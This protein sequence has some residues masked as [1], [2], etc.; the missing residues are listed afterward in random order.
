MTNLPRGM[1]GGPIRDREWSVP[2][3]LG[4]LL[5]L[6]Y[7]RELL[8]L[9]ILVNDCSDGTRSACQW[10]VDRARDEG[11]YRAELHEL[12]LGTTVDNNA[13]QVRD[14]R[15]YAVLRSKWACLCDTERW[16]FSVDSDVQVPHWTLQ[17]LVGLAQRDDYDLLAAVIDN[18]WAPAPEHG[19]NVLV[20]DQDGQAAHS[21]LAHSSREMRT[22]PC[23]VTGACCVINPVVFQQG[24]YYVDDEAE[25]HPAEDNVFCARLINAGYRVGYVPGLRATH[26]HRP[27]VETEWLADPQWWARQA[28]YAAHREVTC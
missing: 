28:A 23:A 25:V 3:W 9:V 12:N 16:I 5:G 4:G 8:S 6:T 15:A 17:G 11:F 1:I 24:I 27:P 7:P 18:N 19:S 2:L 13:R 22:H 20:F 14:Y 10:W 26:W 21:K